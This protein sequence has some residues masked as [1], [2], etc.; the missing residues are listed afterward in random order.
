MEE[1]LGGDCEEDIDIV[2]VPEG[3]LNFKKHATINSN[4][5]SDEFWA[6]MHEYIQLNS[7]IITYIAEVSS[8]SA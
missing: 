7:T 3:L 6:C 5:M 4:I 8:N 2:E 1:M